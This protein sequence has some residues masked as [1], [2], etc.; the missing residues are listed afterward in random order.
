MSHRFTVA[1]AALAFAACS[2]APVR[3]KQPAPLALQAAEGRLVER[4]IVMDATG[5]RPDALRTERYC[6]VPPDAQGNDWARSFIAPFRGAPTPT[7]EGD[8]AEQKTARSK[9]TYLFRVELR[10]ETDAAGQSHLQ[11]VSEWWRLTQ[12][13]C[14]TIGN[15]LVGRM[16]CEYGYDGAVA[17]QAVE[18][19]VHGMLTGL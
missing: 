15:P 3:V 11:A 17:P 7:V 9:C 16:R 6:Y 10:A 14:E 18:P 8:E 19:Y 2:S 4:G 1:G 12:R 5:R 13:H